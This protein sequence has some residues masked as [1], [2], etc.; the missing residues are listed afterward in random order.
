MKF[1]HH[2]WVEVLDENTN[3]FSDKNLHEKNII[4]IMSNTRLLILGSIGANLRG[5]GNIWKR[6]ST[7]AIT[8]IQMCHDKIS[9]RKNVNLKSKSKRCNSTINCQRPRKLS[10]YVFFYGWSK[11]KLNQKMRSKF[12]DALCKFLTADSSS[13]NNPITSYYRQRHVN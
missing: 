7:S 3:K 13:P 6:S 4:S 2:Q 12:S 8:I 9:L 11:M 10:G 1:V 5:R